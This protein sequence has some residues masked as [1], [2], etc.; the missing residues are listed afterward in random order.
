MRSA[1]QSLSRTAAFLAGSLRR[2]AVSLFVAD[3]TCFDRADRQSSR[4]CAA[5][6]HWRNH[7]GGIG[8]VSFVALCLRLFSPKAAGGISR[9]TVI[10]V[11]LLGV[12]GLD[13][14]PT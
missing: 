7:L 9:R 14:P 1:H 6:V 5:S 10:A 3:P 13:V 8:L 12:T 4:R 2:A 11:A